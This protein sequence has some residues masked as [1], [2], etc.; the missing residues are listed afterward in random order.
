MLK[1]V[2]VFGR[3]GQALLALVSWK[4]FIRYVTTSMEVMPVTFRTYRTFF[5]QDQAAL[6]AIPNLIRDF[7]TRLALHSKV[8]MTFIISTMVFLFLFPTLGSAMTGYQTNVKAFVPDSNGNL[9]AFSGFVHHLYTIHDGD[10]INKTKDFVVGLSQ[11]FSG[12]L[13]INLLS[14]SAVLTLAV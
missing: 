8:A 3:G 12:N 9:M 6:I 2:E 5:L 14:V 13:L 10:R 4:V 7:S 11:S 1:L